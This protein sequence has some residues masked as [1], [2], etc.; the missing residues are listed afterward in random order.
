[1]SPV[2]LEKGWITVFGSGRLVESAPAYQ[3]AHQLGG[4]LA[5]SGFGVC[6]GGY[7][8]I[9]EAAPKGA[10]SEN[11]ETAGVIIRG[12]K[13]KPND[14]IK[15]VHEENSWVE[16]LFKLI[17][18]AAGYVVMDGGIGTLN[19]FFLIWEMANK[20]LHTKP[21][22]ILGETPS[23]ISRLLRKSPLVEYADRPYEAQAPS[24]A[25]KYLHENIRV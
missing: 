18:L 17:D 21:I 23:E 13:S 11:G 5:K 25:L 14:W 4:L 19:E 7:R 20:G 1:M 16:R 15:T 3:S 8:G 24:D 9:M 22:I 2:N 12:S 6:T 10:V